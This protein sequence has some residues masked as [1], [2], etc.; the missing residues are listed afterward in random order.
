MSVEEFEEFDLLHHPII[1]DAEETFGSMNA[2]NMFKDLIASKIQKEDALEEADSPISPTI[3]VN[4]DKNEVGKEAESGSMKGK[5]LPS[6]AFTDLTGTCTE[7]S[8]ASVS[9]SVT[10]STDFIFQALSNEIRNTVAQHL[11]P[12]TDKFKLR[13]IRTKSRS[14]KFPVKVRIAMIVSCSRSSRSY[15]FRGVKSIST[16]KTP[17]FDSEDLLGRLNFDLED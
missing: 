5:K 12:K 8:A 16:R 9:T 11:D 2:D 14:L 6:V 4:E 17:N 1:D 3:V 13:A 7:S 15:Y 10:Q